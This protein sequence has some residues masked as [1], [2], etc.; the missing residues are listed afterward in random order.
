[1]INKSHARKAAE[2]FQKINELYQTKDYD[3]IFLILKQNADKYKDA[4][5]M[6]YIS[7]SYKNGEGTEP[8]EE[9]YMSYLGKA[10]KNGYPMAQ[11]L[12]G[13][14]LAMGEENA[15]EKQQKTGFK[16]LKKSIKDKNNTE[17][18]SFLCNYALA[19]YYGRGTKKNEKKSK[20]DFDK[21]CRFWQ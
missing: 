17:I 19:L 6:Y 5:S 9:Q 7:L 21:A 15:P 2:N 20:D 11:Y 4:E 8:N 18:Q 12:Y 14:L 10:A 3:S 13:S 1:M 16:F